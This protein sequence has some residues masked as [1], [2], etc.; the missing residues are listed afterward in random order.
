MHSKTDKIDAK[1]LYKYQSLVEPNMPKVPQIDHNA[2]KE[3]LNVYEGIQASKQR[4]INQLESTNKEDKDL[5]RTLNRIIKNLDNE[6]VKLF[7]KIEL[8]LLKDETT[9][10]DMMLY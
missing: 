4:F 1:I 8:L 10:R 6:A 3:M 5:I 2:I 7:N 9:K